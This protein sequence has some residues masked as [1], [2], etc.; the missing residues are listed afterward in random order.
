LAIRFKSFRRAI[1]IKNDVSFYTDLTNI[2]FVIQE[3]FYFCRF[4]FNQNIKK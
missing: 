1:I 2:L 4:D 3:L